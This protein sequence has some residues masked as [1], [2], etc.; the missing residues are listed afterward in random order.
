MQQRSTE[1]W[2]LFLQIFSNLLYA[3]I[4]FDCHTRESNVS[5]LSDNEEEYHKPT[6]FSLAIS[7]I[8]LALLVLRDVRFLVVTTE[9]PGEEILEDLK[10]KYE[11]VLDH[12]Q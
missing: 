3:M 7:G 12:L 2:D 4:I 11:T 5:L 10:K 9:N 1:K 6:N 8:P